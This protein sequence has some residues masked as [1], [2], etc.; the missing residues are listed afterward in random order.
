MPPYEE[1]PNE[2]EGTQ[3]RLIRFTVKSDVYSKNKIYQPTSSID[4]Q[5]EESDR[6]RRKKTRRKKIFTSSN[7]N[8][9]RRETKHANIQQ[10]HQQQK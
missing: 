8:E 6:R 2:S 1:I 4:P 9:E 5:E 3:Q 7:N 10:Q